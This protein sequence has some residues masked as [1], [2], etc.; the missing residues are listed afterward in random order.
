MLTRKRDISRGGSNQG[1]GSFCRKEERGKTGKLRPED[2]KVGKCRGVH[3]G[4]AEV[5]GEEEKS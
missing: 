5:V 3:E 1:K 4:P 2:Q